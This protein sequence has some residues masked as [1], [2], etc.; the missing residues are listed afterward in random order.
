MNLL[1]SLR[2]VEI[3]EFYPYPS[4][5]LV[6]VAEYDEFIHKTGDPHVKQMFEIILERA[7]NENKSRFFDNKIAFKI[8]YKPTNTILYIG[9]KDS[10]YTLGLEISAERSIVLKN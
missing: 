5:V 6:S 1:Y 3:L 9:M 4:G 8:R 10:K 7:N 2:D